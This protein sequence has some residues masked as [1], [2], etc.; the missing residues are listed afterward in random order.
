MLNRTFQWMG[1][2]V[3]IAVFLLAGCGPKPIQKES[4]LDTPQNHYKQGLRELH[5]GN[6]TSA[7]QEFDRAIAL[8]PKYP[9]G[10]V[11]KSLIANTRRHHI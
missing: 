11:G 6:M 8:D 1:V 2:V 3:L 9:G 4:L 10:Y 7:T 5:N